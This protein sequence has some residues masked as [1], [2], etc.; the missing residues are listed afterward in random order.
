MAGRGPGEAVWREKP[1]AIRGPSSPGG[2]DPKA[3]SSSDSNAARPKG[4][5]PDACADL[6]AAQ[7]QNVALVLVVMEGGCLKR[8]CDG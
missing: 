6:P 5:P 1:A 4:H 3:D 8:R 2:T 7:F